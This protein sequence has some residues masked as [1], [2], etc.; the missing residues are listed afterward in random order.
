M[1]C[2]V[3]RFQIR[4]PAQHLYTSL[5]PRGRIRVEV[6]ENDAPSPKLAESAAVASEMFPANLDLKAGK[7]IDDGL[8]LGGRIHCSVFFQAV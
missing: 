8:E 4:Q 2:Q 5:E 1:G 7:Y 3:D 6:H